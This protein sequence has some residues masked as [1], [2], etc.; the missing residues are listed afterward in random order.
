MKKEKVKDPTLNVETNP[1]LPKWLTL[2]RIA[3]GIM[4]ILKGFS[5]F[6]DSARLN[7]LFEMT[8]LGIFNTNTETWAFIITY[9]HILC[10]VFIGVG[11]L[12]RWASIAMIPFLIGALF[13]VN[14][15]S[16]LA[17]GTGEFAYS[18]IAFILL[19]IF[20]W[21]GSGSISAD[22]FFRNY[23]KAGIEPGH[24]EEFLN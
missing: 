22:E 23:T 7:N 14:I 18:L 17:L 3:L 16:G 24:T 6:R 11:F 5:F 9:A 21:F 12:T 1:W 2:F 19:I 8:E 4:L 13:F 20:A 15:K 10:G